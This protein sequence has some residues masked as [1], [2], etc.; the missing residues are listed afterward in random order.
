MQFTYNNN[1]RNG[2][3]SKSC[4]IIINHI[5]PN[6]EKLLRDYNVDVAIWAHEHNYERFWPMYNFT[7]MNGTTKPDE[8]YT[9]AG[10]TIHMITGSAVSTLYLIV[11]EIMR[12]SLS[13]LKVI[14][15][16]TFIIHMS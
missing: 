1:T 9:D 7:V 4:F 16:D 11:Y 15:R 3:W 14:N 13:F 10:A 6:T 8:P 5:R 12:L 2:I